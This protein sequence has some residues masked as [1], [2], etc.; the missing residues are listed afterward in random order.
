MVALIGRDTTANIASPTSVAAV[1]TPIQGPI[2]APTP[3]S[4]G[5]VVAGIP[6]SVLV[7]LGIIG[8]FS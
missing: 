2:D 8:G 4:P 3:M 1:A 5:E 7:M 6:Q